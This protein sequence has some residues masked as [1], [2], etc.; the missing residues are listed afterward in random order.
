MNYLES[1]IDEVLSTLRIEHKKLTTEEIN[2]LIKALTRR[3]FTTENT[4]LD[5]MNFNE[6][7]S[8][9]NSNF[10]KEITR[11]I[12]KKNLTLIVYDTNYRAW[13]I[14]TPQNIEY[15]IGETTG[16]PFWLTDR[17]LTFLIHLDDH[18]CV[19]SAEKG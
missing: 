16:Y 6:T 4:T 2:S 3:F 5:P 8:E 14:N 18:D 19:S 1:E 10:W 7:N 9:Y 11:R 13:E 17:N 12:N 15:L